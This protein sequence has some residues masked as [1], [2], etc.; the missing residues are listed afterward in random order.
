MVQH[1][2]PCSQVERGLE[3]NQWFM[4]DRGRKIAIIRLLE[5]GGHTGELYRSTTYPAEPSQRILIGYFPTLS[6]AAHFTWTEWIRQNSSA[7]DRK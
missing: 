4:V 7:S 6:M 3:A 1:W 2:T 5:V